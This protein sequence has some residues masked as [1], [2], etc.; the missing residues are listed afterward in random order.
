MISFPFKVS[1]RTENRISFWTNKIANK[2]SW[3]WK[4]AWIT[5]ILRDLKMMPQKELSFH[6]KRKQTTKEFSHWKKY[7]LNTHFTILESVYIIDRQSSEKPYCRLFRKTWKEMFFLASITQKALTRE[8]ISYVLRNV[9]FLYIII[10]MMS[11][12]A[13]YNKKSSLGLQKK[14]RMGRYNPASENL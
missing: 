6:G 9:Y 10:I 8:W 2:S 3:K 11:I 1:P 4:I 14:K 12:I 5:L 7:M 13:P